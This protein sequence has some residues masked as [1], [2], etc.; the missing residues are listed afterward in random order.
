MTQICA[1]VLNWNNYEDTKNCI[2]SLEKSGLTNGRI[3]LVDNG[4]TDES[5]VRL[6]SYFGQRILI[7]QNIENKGFAAGIN[8]GINVA[9]KQNYEY[10]LLVN[11][12]AILD[13]ECLKKLI[14]AFEEKCE[15]GI[16]GPR[17]Y[18]HSKPDVVWQG[19]GYF[20][21][22]TGGNVVPEKNKKTIKHSIKNK[23]VSF[24]TGCVMLI[25]R[26]VIEKTGLFNER[27]YFY[28]EDVDYCLR[29]M[30]SGFTLLY[31]PEAL[32][33]HKVEGIKITEFAFFQRARS[34]IIVLRDNFNVSYFIYGIF[35]HILYYTPYKLIQSISKL[36]LRPFWAWIMGSFAGLKDSRKLFT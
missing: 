34:R 15:I 6:R 26:N 3:I 24:L 32:V 1:I 4:S 22:L 31:V 9:Y 2:L 18:Y 20:N 13:K 16:T 23:K 12:D 35:M 36:S 30:K 19:G 27:I 8:V 14:A 29:A 11:N 17:I 25:K 5:N 7:I 28:E 10:F 21:Y 33:W